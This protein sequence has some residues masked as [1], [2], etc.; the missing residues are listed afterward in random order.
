MKHPI[1]YFYWML[2]L[3][4]VASSGFGSQWLNH[5]L[6]GASGDNVVLTSKLS[7]LPKDLGAWKGKD[8]QMDQRVI[9][10]S[11]A[12]DY[13][14]R[15][16]VDVNLS[17]S[18][19]VYIA[20]AFRPSKLLGHRPGVCFPAHGWSHVGDEKDTVYTRDNKKI[21]CNFY[22]FTRQTNGFQGVVVLNYYILHGG[23]TSEWKDFWGVSGRLPNL[24]GAK[25][26][27]VIQVQASTLI[28]NEKAFEQAKNNVKDFI[29]AAA[30]EIEKLLPEIKPNLSK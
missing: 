13:L 18:V 27:Y 9:Q 1:N 26:Y 2:A 29:E 3:V 17:R 14:Y 10:I 7:Q 25:D 24:K 21:E 22:R 4:I 5:Y 6:N 23:Y 12:D 30:P 28:T 16:Y 11:G 20:F 19:E 15:Q 8:V